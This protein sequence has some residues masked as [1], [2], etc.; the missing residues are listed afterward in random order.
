MQGC[1]SRRPTIKAPQVSPE[2]DNPWTL[3]FGP[4][5]NCYSLCSNSRIVI[6]CSC[7][8]FMTSEYPLEAGRNLSENLDASL[9]VIE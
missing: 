7:G 2:R 1:A 4:T 9:D 8:G 6:F 5:F 3:N